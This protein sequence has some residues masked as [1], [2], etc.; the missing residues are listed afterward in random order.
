MKVS[1]PSS[2][3]DGQQVRISDT[4]EDRLYDLKKPVR[5]CLAAT[6]GGAAPANP[7]LHVTCYNA[8]RAADEPKHRKRIGAVRPAGLFGDLELDTRVENEL[9]L[10]ASIEPPASARTQL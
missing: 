9:C 2:F 6:I 4:F 1:S 3:P 10:P 5:L 7:G 8:V